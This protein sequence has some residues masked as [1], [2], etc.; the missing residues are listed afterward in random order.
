LRFRKFIA[1]QHLRENL[2]RKPSI[3]TAQAGDGEDRLPHRF[4]RRHHAHA[5]RFGKHGALTDQVFQGTGG[6][7]A[8]DRFIRFK[9]ITQL[10]RDSRHFAPRGHLRLIGFNGHAAHIRHRGI[11]ADLAHNI[12][13]PPDGEGED[14]QDEKRLGDPGGGKATHEGNHETSD[15]RRK[16]RRER[17]DAC[18]APGWRLANHARMNTLAPGGTPA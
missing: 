8:A 4:F 13:N 5:L 1:A 3:S 15:Y 18:Q 11:A 14:E 7:R 12:L 9:A 2:A 6:N 16:R 10:A 17:P